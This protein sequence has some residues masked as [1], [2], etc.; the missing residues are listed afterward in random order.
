MKYE[1]LHE[2]HG[3]EEELAMKYDVPTFDE[4]KAWCQE[5]VRPLVHDYIYNN[6]P[7][8]PTMS[9]AQNWSAVQRLA[10][11]VVYFIHCAGHPQRVLIINR[12]FALRLLEEEGEIPTE[13]EG[14][15]LAFDEKALPQIASL[16]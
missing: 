14:I 6:G 11:T 8:P 1:L 16:G 12:E 15:P 3:V 10:F 9:K 4:Y 13:F 2:S 5:H 7:Q